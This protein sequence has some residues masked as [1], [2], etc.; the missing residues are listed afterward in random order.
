[1]VKSG[2]LSSTKG[3]IGKLLNL[4]PVVVVTNEGTIKSFGKPFT[5]KQSMRLVMKE[6]EK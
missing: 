1:M 4:K 2:R 3:V 6:F 5:L